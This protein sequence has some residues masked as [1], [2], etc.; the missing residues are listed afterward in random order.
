MSR[1]AALVAVGTAFW[2]VTG[3]AAGPPQQCRFTHRPL[4]VGDEAR[5]TIR[6]AVD[7]KTV[8][9]QDGQVVSITDQTL[10]R[11]E[12]SVAL[13]LPPEPGQTAKVRITYNTSTQTTQTRGGDE[14][15]EDRP[16][17]GKTYFVARVGEDLVITDEQGAAPPEDQRTIVARSLAGL[18]RPNPLAA[19]LN[20]RT[21]A[22]GETVRLPPSSASGCWPAGMSRWPSCRSM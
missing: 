2:S 22:V 17:A 7:L 15:I 1:L 10:E 20:G 11:S 12:E 13:R 18:G 21:L 3:V 9:A 4:A 16:V 8:L 14:S 19:F 5:E 6:L